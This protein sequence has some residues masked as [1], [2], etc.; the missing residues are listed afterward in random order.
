MYDTDLTAEK[1]VGAEALHVRLQRD[2]L[3]ALHRLRWQTISLRA[4]LYPLAGA[5]LERRGRGAVG[6]ERKGTT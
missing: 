2:F 5:W 3:A 1:Q 6:A 4:H